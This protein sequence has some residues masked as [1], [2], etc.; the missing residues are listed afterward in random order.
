MTKGKKLK[1]IISIILGIIVIMIALTFIKI[2]FNRYWKTQDIFNSPI[3]KI[4]LA[5]Y[6]EYFSGWVEFSDEDLIQI[7]VDYFNSIDLQHSVGTD[8]ATACAICAPMDGGV[9]YEITVYTENSKTHF[10]FDR[11]DR[12]YFPNS[13]RKFKVSGGEFP[14][15]DTYKT[16]E[17]RHGLVKPK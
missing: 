16:A 15:F 17:E 14:F 5:S 2:P 11:S 7:W 4:E 1:I 8:L 10:T 3:T 12:M 13:L 6:P 9:A